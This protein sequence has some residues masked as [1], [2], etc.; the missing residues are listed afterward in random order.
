MLSPPITP[1]PSLATMP[2]TKTWLPTTRQLD[3]VCGGG[4][5]TCGLE[6]FFFMA[7]P[8]IAG[9]PGGRDGEETPVA[10]DALECLWSPIHEADAGTGDEILHGVGDE[11]LARTRERGDPGADVNSDAADF[12]ADDLALARV[13]PR[14]YLDAEGPHALAD[15]LGAANG[16]GRT[17]EGRE[18]AVT[19]GVDFAPAEARELATREG[20]VAV[21]QLVPPS[22]T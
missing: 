8:W 7:S 10:G 2:A 6:I 1:P 4:S 20:V 15:R 18:E 13:E 11:D 9:S 21:E 22:V 14:A 16:A 19:G 3:H 5:G 12:L 17:I